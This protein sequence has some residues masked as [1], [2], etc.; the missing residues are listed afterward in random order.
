MHIDLKGSKTA[1]RSE[2]K[3][4]RNL[5]APE[6]MAQASVA[7]AKR[8]NDLL[9]VQKARTIMG[10]ASIQNE[11]ALESFYEQQRRQGRTI[12]LP[13]VQGDLIEAVEWKG[14]KETK[15]SS[16]GICEP[17][18]S[19][20][21]PEEI[22][23]VL[24]PGLAFDGRGFRLGY[25]RGYYDRFLPELR[26]GAFK[27]GICYEFQVVESVFPHAEDVSMHWIVTDHSELVIDWDFF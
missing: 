9:P 22:D 16:F 21:P 15:V 18:G 2:M 20:F 8:I 4:Q 5:L 11:V 25:G 12:L 14:W 23:V 10:Y 7:I 6:Q 1:L 17:V 26:P 24:V 13:R 19:S 27:C 3:A